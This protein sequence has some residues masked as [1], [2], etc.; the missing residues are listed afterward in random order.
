M[1]HSFFIHI[2]LKHFVF[3][4]LYLYFIIL[5]LLGMV[6]N[7]HNFVAFFGG[8]HIIQ[9]HLLQVQNIYIICIILYIKL[10][11]LLQSKRMLGRTMIK[12]MQN[13]SNTKVQ[14]KTGRPVTPYRTMGVVSSV[15]S[16][17]SHPDLLLIQHPLF[18]I[19]PVLNT[20]LSL[21]EPL[22]LYKGYNAI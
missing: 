17:Y 8:T 22:Q 1:F 15:R 13:K 3:D 18:Q 6:K 5:L 9:L 4:N 7:A 20:G 16:S 21:S 14:T 10:K 11:L 2:I 19:T 12:Q